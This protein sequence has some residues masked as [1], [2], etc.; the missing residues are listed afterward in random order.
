MS[1]IATP[2]DTRLT[3]GD[4]HFHVRQWSESGPPILLLHGLASSAQTWNLVA[5]LLAPD[6]QVI[7]LDERG[8][9]QSDKPDSG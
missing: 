9:G 6:Y 4:L 7:A 3:V 8:H 2:K 1:A 5:P